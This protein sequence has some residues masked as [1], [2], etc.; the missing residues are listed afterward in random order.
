MSALVRRVVQLSIDFSRLIHVV[1]V[2]G[3]SSISDNL[4]TTKALVSSP[5]FLTLIDLGE[6]ATFELFSARF[7][8]TEILRGTSI[9]RTG[10][11][12]CW[13][14]VD[15]VSHILTS[16]RFEFGFLFL[17]EDHSQEYSG[18]HGQYGPEIFGA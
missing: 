17:Y 1:L 16:I 6:R 8:R 14:R 7:T 4:L 18:T 10:L 13:V 9:E 12:L 5:I 2:S 3:I 15:R 11:T